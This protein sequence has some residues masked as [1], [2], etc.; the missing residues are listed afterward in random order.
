[1]HAPIAMSAL[2]LG[3]NVYC[4]KPLTHDLY[5]A[6][7]LTEYARWRKVVTQMGIQIHSSSFY[8]MAVLLVQAG[9]IGRIKEVHSWNGNAWGDPT[10]GRTFPI[11]CRGDSTG[12]FGLGCAP[13]GPLSARST[14]TRST[15]ASA[16]T[17]AP[18]R[19]ATWLA[20]SSTRIRRPRIDGAFASVRSEGSAPNQ[21]NWPLTAGPI[22][23]SRHGLYRG[24]DAPGDWYDGTQKTAASHPRP[25]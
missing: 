4:Q 13:S 17:S 21:W 16:S 11:P 9:A 20:I 12:T 8:R 19:S 18:A 2:Q 3:K 1:M 15:G 6:R 7:K 22:R 25:A 23:L 24:Q 5:E 14:I 10:R